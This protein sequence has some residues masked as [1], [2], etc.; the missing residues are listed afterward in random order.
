M[1]AFD[2]S[3]GGEDPMEALRRLLRDLG[4]PEDMDVNDA[5]AR[6]DLFRMMMQ[7]LMPSDGMSDE[8]VVWETVRQMARQLVASLGPDPSANSRVSRQVTDAVHLAEL[9]LSEATVLPP[10]PMTAVVW[11]R[12]EWIEA[13]LP[14]WKSMIEPVIGTLASAISQA[15]QH[16]LAD[17]TEGEADGEMVGLQSIMHPILSRAISA[18]F[19]AHVGEGLGQAATTTMTGTD[20]G[21][22]LFPTASVG[23]L[24]TNLAAIQQQAELDEEELLLYCSLREVARQRLFLE[25]GW[26]APQIIALVQHF[27]REIRVDP[28]AIATAMEDALPD[29]LSAESMA[30]FQTDFS[31]I[32]FMPDQSDEQREILERLSTLLALVEGWVDDVTASVASQRLPGW[33]AVSES[34][35]RHRATS[36]PAQ[37]MVTPL[38]GLSATPRVIREASVFW[39]AVREARGIDGRDALWK[40]PDSMPQPQDVADPEGFLAR[41]TSQEDPWDDE[42]RRFLSGGE[43]EA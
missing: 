33:E 36:R 41:P 4:L 38:I 17:Q 12:A 40:Y 7:R 15:A 20:L 3:H 8:T 31:T 32:L 34:L 9:W 27:A 30:A 16:R 21:L 42:L 28:D 5:E 43:G 26:I 25:V 37:T 24:P 22:P 10:S 35:R 23:I 19:G 2:L 11:S 6:T 1:D 13:S 29:H 14:A 18:M 39:A